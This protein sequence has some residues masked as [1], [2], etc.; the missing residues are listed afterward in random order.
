MAD[1]EEENFVTE[2]VLDKRTTQT[3][4][5]E[6][7]VKWEGFE[8]EDNTWEPIEYLNCPDLIEAF[9][10]KLK[11]NSKKSDKSEGN[12]KKKSSDQNNNKE[13]KKKEKETES[14]GNKKDS[15]KGK[16]PEEDIVEL[17][18]TEDEEEFVVENIVEKRSGK[19]G[20]VEYL[21]KWKGYDSKD[22][23]WEEKDS[24]DCK[25]LIT[26]FE[27]K[28]G[29]KTKDDKRKVPE[30]IVDKQKRKTGKIEYLVKW[31]G[32]DEFDNSWEEAK[33]T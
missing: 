1:A 25:D 8:S 6:Y 19:N 30:A 33:K 28:N 24:L 4:V 15:D 9:E 21:V 2:K 14:K 16:A 7:F 23:T 11:Q 18:D 32:L 5:V 17:G 22:N 29:S 3:G 26:K 10:K 12:S 27:K 20:K 13:N 31:K